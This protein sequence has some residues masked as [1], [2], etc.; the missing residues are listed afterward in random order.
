MKTVKGSSQVTQLISLSL[1]S[2]KA[3]PGHQQVLLHYAVNL[4]LS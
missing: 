3:V 2:G 1:V 4:P